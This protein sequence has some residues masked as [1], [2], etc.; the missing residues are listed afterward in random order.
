VRDLLQRPERVEREFLQN[1]V[2]GK[3]GDD[4]A[5]PV[6]GQTAGDPGELGDQPGDGVRAVHQQ[7]QPP[8]L[9]REP[10][11]AGVRAVVRR[12]QHD[13]RGPAYGGQLDGL[14]PGA[15][16]RPR[17]GRVE[18]VD[19]GAP[20]IRVGRPDG[21]AGSPPGH[22]LPDVHPG[23]DVRHSAAFRPHSHAPMPKGD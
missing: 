2:A 14:D 19:D 22:R 16:H 21:R 6:R 10:Q 12:A 20:Q 23:L 7:G 4:P 3:V 5:D 8:L 13:V 18:P 11:V 1:P 9:R 15:Q 17:P